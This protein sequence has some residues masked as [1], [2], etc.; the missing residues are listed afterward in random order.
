MVIVDGVL[1][2]E[3]LYGMTRKGPVWGEG[4]ERRR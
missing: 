4:I 2:M 3:V 1:R